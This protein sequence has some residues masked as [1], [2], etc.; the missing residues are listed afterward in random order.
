MTCPCRWA[1]LE[2]WTLGAVTLRSVSLATVRSARAF[3]FAAA[4]AGVAGNTVATA[5]S[6]IALPGPSGM[7]TRRGRFTLA[8]PEITY[9]P[10]GGC[11]TLGGA[12][13]S[14]TSRRPLAAAVSSQGR[15][16]DGVRSGEHQS[17]RLMR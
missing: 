17:L 2:T 3:P 9:G 12:S 6:R 4:P 11:A 16:I 5:V 13:S 1:L 14:A 8:T 7:W 10:L 15:P